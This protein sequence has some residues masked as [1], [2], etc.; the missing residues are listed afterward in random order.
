MQTDMNQNYRSPVSL[1][2]KYTKP[3]TSA[4]EVGWDLPEAEWHDNQHFPRMRCHLTKADQDLN[5]NN[6]RD[7]MILRRVG[8]KC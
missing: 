2:Q 3:V 5:L 6:V 7:H 8:M 1:P 4:Q